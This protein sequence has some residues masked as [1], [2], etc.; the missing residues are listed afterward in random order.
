[1]LLA[2]ALAAVA[3]ADD[4][5]VPHSRIHEIWAVDQSNTTGTTSGGALYVYDSRGM[6]AGTGSRAERIDLGG[7]ASELCLAQTG[8]APVRPHMILFNRRGSH[9][10]LSFVASGHVL[11]IDARTRAPL[12]CI[13]VGAQAHAA[14]P[15]PDESYVVVANQNGKLVQR[16]KTDYRTNTF[17]LEPE[18]TLDLVTGTTPSGAP[19]EDPALRPDN[20][21]ICPLIDSSS[22][23]AFVTLRGG[24]MFVLDSRA[25][26]MRI[27]AEYDRSTI[28]G[29]GCGGLESGGRMYVN[30]GG[31]TAANL[32]EFDVYAFN[33]AE[34]RNAAGTGPCSGAG[35]NLPAPKLVVSQDDRD[36]VDS[37]GAVLTG[38]GR[39]LWVADRSGNRIVV[40]STATDQVVG[41]I[42]LVGKL[43]DD[44]SPDLLDVSPRGDRVYVS[45]RGKLPL[46]GDPHVS[47]GSTPG[48]GVIEVKHGGRSGRLVEIARIANVDVGGVD[49]ADPHGLRV[50]ER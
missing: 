47:T 29:N 16:I 36:P 20:A 41:E 19:R 10:V 37:H 45:L 46:S 26:P 34:F 49:R 44:P 32:S 40:L 31:G 21:P 11:F 30:S 9:A 27:V 25:T 4:R 33:L 39:Y 42:P 48:V 28:H 7:A 50:R 14:V 23:L 38:D 43:S 2:V 13:D 24:G 6:S 15:A 35:P 5:G 1:M 8:S 17:A 12:A 3:L 18:A 22:R